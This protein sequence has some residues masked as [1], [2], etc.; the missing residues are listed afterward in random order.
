MKNFSSFSLF[1][2]ISLFIFTSCG[3][4]KQP[5]FKDIGTNQTAFVIPMEQGNTEGQKMLKSVQY[6]EKKKVSAKRV[7]IEQKSVST[8]RMWWSYQWIPTD[9]VV[10][11]DRAPVT[12]EWIDEE[13]S[14]AHGMA[15]NV[16]SKESIGFMVPVNSTASVLEEDASTFLYWY[17]GQSIGYVM[18][19]NVRP[20]ILDKFT[21]E[22]GNLDLEQCQNRRNQIYEK[23]IDSTIKF[24]KSYGLTIINLGVAGEYTYTDP[25]IQEAINKKFISQMSITAA[26]NEV[27]AANKFAAAAEA[28]KKQKELDAD[29]QLKTSLAKAIEDGKIQ[30]PQNLVISDNASLFDLFGIKNINSSKK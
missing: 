11:V 25:K 9:T 22:F 30:F 7:Y 24:F 13:E 17:G 27:A 5:K 23:T 15:L 18:D 19:H 20:F 28:I 26:E 29:V 8:G 4:Y 6:L 14:D 2:M 16:A 21:K 1:A 12:R 10:V 3:P